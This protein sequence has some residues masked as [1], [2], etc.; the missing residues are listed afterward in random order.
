MIQELLSDPTMAALAKSLQGA[1]A[2]QE[3]LS[4]NL[5]NAE[6]PGY[7]RREV[8]FEE[9]LAAAW[10]EGEG[11]P[12]EIQRR[13]SALEFT[14]IEDTSR[15]PGPDGNN[16]ALESEM[17]ELAKNA[18]RFDSSATVLSLKGRMLRTAIHEGRR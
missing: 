7:V 14:A 17:T 1:G 3:A 10:E 9:A 11:R 18:L 2:R 12:E 15:A 4:A 16:V 13:L 8:H 5:A 6:T